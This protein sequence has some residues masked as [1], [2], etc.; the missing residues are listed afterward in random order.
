M[1]ALDGVVTKY[2]KLDAIQCTT[3]S[4]VL[5]RVKTN[6]LLQSAAFG[7]KILPKKGVS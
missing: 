4:E 7:G 2:L 1:A 6:K 3:L 5:Y